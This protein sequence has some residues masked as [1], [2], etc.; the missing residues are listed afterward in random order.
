[1]NTNKT[2]WILLIETEEEKRK[3]GQTARKPMMSKEGIYAIVN[4]IIGDSSMDNDL[5]HF[6]ELEKHKVSCVSLFGDRN[7]ILETLAQW[8]V[9]DSAKDDK[10][11]HLKPGLYA[12]VTKPIEKGEEIEQR[13]DAAEYVVYF[14]YW[15]NPQELS[16]LSI[17][18]AACAYL[19]YL[20]EISHHLYFCLPASDDLFSRSTASSSSASPS[21]SSSSSSSSVRPGRVGMRLN[22][23]TKFETIEDSVKVSPKVAIKSGIRNNNRK[24]LLVPSVKCAVLSTTKSEVLPPLLR[25][26]SLESAVTTFKQLRGVYGI[27]VSGLKRKARVEFLRCVLIPTEAKEVMEQYNQNRP[28]I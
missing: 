9:I 27:D 23:S 24:T 1:M 17:S 12:I 19:T 18:S 21:S 8:K 3:L 22:F 20:K 2:E 4:K 6:A 26:C 5:I 10:Y 15:P 13:Q 7:I 16:Q 14:L 11:T 28:S 25:D